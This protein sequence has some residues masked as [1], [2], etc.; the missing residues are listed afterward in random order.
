MSAFG[1]IVIGKN[2]VPSL[3][4]TVLLM[5]AIPVGFFICWRRRHKAQTR[6]SWLLA[7][8]A[9]FILRSHHIVDVVFIHGINFFLPGLIH[10]PLV[11][12]CYPVH[13]RLIPAETG[14]DHAQRIEYS[15]VDER[16]CSVTQ[17]G[18]VNAVGA[19]STDIHLNAQDGARTSVHVEV[20]GTSVTQPE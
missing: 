1:Q 15:A 2:S 12:C 14:V 13:D 7:G 18:L 3:I 5:V 20:A 8:A 17:D 9:G 4:I 16:V 6:I 10:F 19:G 11:Q